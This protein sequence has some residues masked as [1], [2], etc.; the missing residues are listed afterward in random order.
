[1]QPKWK[2]R[3][4]LIGLAGAVMWAS[5]GCAQERD[6]INRVQYNAM[7]KG[8]FVGQSLSDPT[9]DPEFYM[10]NTVTDVPYGA[11][12]DGLFTATYA[13]PVTRVKW[14]ISEDA[15]IA[16]LTYEK[17]KDSDFYGAR[18][19]DKGQVVAMFAIQSHFDIRR[20]YNPQTGEELNVIEENT[21]D[22]PWFQRQ[23]MRVDWSRNMVTDGYEVDTLSQIGIFG[24]V[25]FEPVSY[26]VMD[27]ANADAPAFDEKN[28]YFD[29]TTKAYA[30]PQNIDTPWG[31]FPAC[32]LPAD[33]GGTYPV[34]NCNPTEITL[35]LS[36]KKVV[37][38]D[39]E[40]FDQTG[41][42]QEAFGWFTED[43]NGYDRHY[44]VLDQKWH[45]FAAKYNIWQKSHIEGTQCAVDYW[46]DAK[47]NIGKFQVDGNG[48]FVVGPNGLPVADPNGKPF[49]GTPIGADVHRLASDGKTEADC[50]F[51]DGNGAIMHPGSTCDEFVHKCTIPLRDRKTKT[52]PWYYGPGSP[53]DLFP[54]TNHSV[55]AWNIAVKRATQIGQKADAERVGLDGSGYITSEDDL[56]NRT[57]GG[58]SIPDIFVLCHNPVIETDNPACGK[59][60]LIARVGDLRYS[61]VNLVNDPQTP[62]PW[63]IMVDAVDPITGEKIATSVN[64]WVHILDIASQGTVD[65][66]RWINGEITD[67]QI[68]SGEYLRDWA[69]VS[70]L[71][72]KEFR[73]ETLSKEEIQ[74]RIHS[75]NDGLAALNGLT[76]ADQA[77]PK[78]LRITKASR[79]L[80]AA[81]GPSATPDF[82]AF[83]TKAIGSEFEARM[84]TP[85]MI[86][87]AGMDPQSPVANNP[88]LI[89]RASMFR[90]MNPT[91]SKWIR[92]QKEKTMAKVGACMVQQPEP[93][94]YVGLARQAQ[95]LYP[96]PDKNDPNFAAKK[97]ARDRSLLQWIREQFHVAVIEHE[98]GHS[99]GERH[100]F[101]GSQDSLNYH[102]QYWQLRTRNGAE[103]PCKDVMTPNADGTTCV[104]PRWMDPV[105]EDEVNGLIWKWGST[106]VMDYPGDATQ[107]MNDLGPYDKAAMR[108]MYGGV[109]DVDEDA[110]DGTDKGKA[111]VGVLD[112]FGGIGGYTVGDTHYSNYNDKYKV[113]GTCSAPTDPKDPLSAKCTGIPMRYIPMRDMEN[114]DKYGKAVTAVRPDLVAN[115]A[116]TKDKVANGRK[117]IR[118]PYMFGSDEYADTGNLPIF[119]FDAG[120]DNYE[121]MQYT[122][123]TYENRYIFDNFRRDR[124]TF[125]S[126]AVIGRT[127]SRYL[128]R[129]QGFVKSFA[130]LIGFQSNPESAKSDPGNL[131]PLSM[132]CSD[133]LATFARIITRPEPG[134][135]NLRQPVDTGMVLPFGTG[136]DINGQI[137]NPGG[138]FKIRLGSGEGRWI[139]NEYDYTQGYYWS[140]YQKWA[141]SFYEKNDAAYF[142]WEAYNHFVQNSKEDYVDGRY[143]NLNFAS[144]FPEQMRRL[145]ANIMAG[146]PMTLGPYINNG[147]GGLSKDGFGT[148]RYLPWEKYDKTVSSTV[149]LDYPANSVV[150]DP[151]VG[152]EEQIPLMI[153][154][155]WFGMSNLTNDVISQMRIWTPDGKE[156]VTIPVSETVRFRDPYTG[157]VYVARTYGTESINSARGPVQKTMGARMIQYANEMAAKAFNSS[158]T[159]TDKDGVS[160]PKY[161]VTAPKDFATSQKVKGFVSNLE[162]GRLL[163]NYFGMG[164]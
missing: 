44:G 119:R 5:A 139:H 32:F 147:A 13:Q 79:N 127:E 45:R 87:A 124:T 101:A 142:L 73:P 82:E 42:R 121:Q 112:G 30:T 106:T 20:A 66:L 92:Q 40:P 138:D 144:V 86:Q 137:N 160:Y 46:R 152:F 163:S 113:L 120:A 76:P 80:A 83:R 132:A 57:N 114:V 7:D 130:L 16:R 99:V 58:E 67:D 28:G 131:M 153:Y 37:D 88:T 143:K 68:A 109:V 26:A 4:G 69:A 31:E 39:F 6:A 116:R 95:K 52:I 98:M 55:D 56:T 15:L 51:T 85:D 156:A 94:S 151:L 110:V 47:G 61:M 9:D 36:F 54:S 161:D 115:F 164:I 125:S 2:A 71:G 49:P 107:D 108:Y 38:T 1:M 159:V 75:S 60:G 128:D 105:T 103:K 17:V 29:V 50:A 53:S 122:I 21:S 141:G 3:L 24:G 96:M 43:R 23:Y 135:Y 34:G 146:D 63:G 90:G 77:G 155:A 33:Y 8:F 157:I 129:I 162:F 126:R 84:I 10:R 145:F 104:G 27:P 81:M 149:N 65:I 89:N 74:A 97:S 140:S 158:G 14:E 136:Q 41:I 48:D 91:F 117:L 93:A 22:R 118:H 25:K 123:S 35:R 72:T 62:S 134:G 111:Y 59:P 102:L 150:L 148:V 18:D 12:Q 64:E 100:N 11:M 19:T 70:Q 133:A 78:E 154:T